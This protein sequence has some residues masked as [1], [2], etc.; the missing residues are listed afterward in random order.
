MPRALIP[1]LSH[2]HS[3]T[4]SL[5]PALSPSRI[6]REH[7][8]TL[9]LPNPPPLSLSCS[10]TRSVFLSLSLSQH[11]KTAGNTCWRCG[12]TQRHLSASS[13]IHSGTGPNSELAPNQIPAQ[14]TKFGNR[15]TKPI[16]R[17][18]DRPKHEIRNLRHES[19]CPTPKTSK[20]QGTRA[21]AAA[22]HNVIFQP[23][24]RSTPGQVQTPNSLQIIAAQHTKFGN[25]KTK[26][27]IRSPN[28][29]KHEIRNLKHESI[30]PTP[31]T[32]NPGEGLGLRVKETSGIGIARNLKPD[33]RNPEPGTKPKTG[34]WNRIPEIRS[35]QLCNP[36]AKA[37]NLIL[38]TSWP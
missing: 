24:Q 34:N 21:G 5:S 9:P 8:L 37:R 29:R 18:P 23:L 26:P 36:K 30:C 35:P 10:H 6:G 12:Y 13:T 16:I 28:R 25:R 19:I 17:S 22:I 3:H 7:V 14:H 2:T 32:S 4:S 38:M 11:L 33:Y 20:R 1:P 27:I 31:E 15:K